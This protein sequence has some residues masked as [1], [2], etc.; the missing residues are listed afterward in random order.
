MILKLLEDTVK[1][2][3]IS[4]FSF[5]KIELETTWGIICMNYK[6]KLIVFGN[7]HLAKVYSTS[8]Y[9]YRCMAPH[10]RLR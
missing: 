3:E 10:S 1:N 6:G 7:P 5:V 4:N 8:T 9:V 2:S